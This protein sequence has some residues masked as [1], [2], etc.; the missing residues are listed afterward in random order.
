MRRTVVPFIFMMLFATSA[1]AV[2]T[3]ADVRERF[4]RERHKLI[5]SEEQQR[6]IM[7]SLFEINKKIK[8]LVSEKS[9]TEQERMT[10][11]ASTRT[12]AERILELQSRIKT[13]RSLLQ[14]R[15]NAIYKLGGQGLARLLFSSSNSAELERNLKILGLVAKH[16]LNL[17]KDY[18]KSA[19]ELSQKQTKFLARLA[20][21]KKVEKRVS[22]QERRIAGES[23]AKARI[24]ESIRKNEVK[25]LSR[26]RALR[27]QTLRLGG[28]VDDELL[29]LLLK[30]SFFE[31]KGQ[32]SAPIEGVV[33]RRFG[34]WKD[35]EFNVT[36]NHK[37][38]FF[39][40]PR[41]S[42][43][44]AVFPGKVAYNGMIE[45]FG[46]TLILD[47]GDHYY[48][49]YSGLAQILVPADQEILEGQRIASVND[50]LYFE[51]RHFSEPY[52]P[53]QWMKGRQP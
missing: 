39:H 25:A 35:S 6:A 4:E 31:K 38:V 32:L 16:D 15:L 12:L 43:V 37:G 34:L 18:S 50:G 44:S 47:H 5:A 19:E 9:K 48:S 52:D 13:Q 2:A 36:L 21:L 26:L 51:I 17:M 46:P 45:G 1:V 8:Q 49:V 27:E 40:A 20:A 22:E 53:L 7:S 30:P 24:L 10:L 29:D 28:I 42:A 33:I 3:P 14:V 23:A 41:G 11:E